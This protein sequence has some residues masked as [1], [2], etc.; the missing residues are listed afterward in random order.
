MMRLMQGRSRR[1]SRARRLIPRS[2]RRISR[3]RILRMSSGDRKR[4]LLC[5]LVIRGLGIMGCN[6]TFFF[7]CFVFN[8]R[9]LICICLQERRAQDNRRRTLPRPRR[10]RRNL[11]SQRLRPQEIVLRPMRTHRQRRPR[12]RQ[13]HLAQND[14]GRRGHRAE[15]QLTPQPPD[16]GMGYRSRQQEFQLLPHVRFSSLRVLDP[17]PLLL[18]AA[19]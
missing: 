3:R 10:S 13:R 16:P 9:K 8:W 2:M 1:S 19:S 7:F 5:Y 6:C 14:C 15:D 17:Q 4:R 11:Q 18:A 12:L